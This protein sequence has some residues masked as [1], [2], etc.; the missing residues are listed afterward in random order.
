MDIALLLARLVLTAVFIVSGVGKLADL[1]GSRKATAGFGVPERFVPTAAVL[2]PIAE[3]I[4]A[5]ALLFTA[6]AWWGGL[7]GLALLILFIGVIGFNLA[8]GRTPDCHCFGQLHS[9]PIGWSTIVRNV[10]L[11]A[12]AAF[13]VV[14]GWNDPGTSAFAWL[15]S[16]SGS[17]VALL[18]GG[19]IFA[20]V[21]AASGWVVINLMEQNGRL[22]SRVEA[23]EQS[24]AT[25]SALPVSPPAA[26]TPA[27]RL[28]LEVGA[29]APAFE[30]PDLTGAMH[31]L[32]SVQVSATP[33]LLLFTDPGCD[34]CNRM[35][36]EVARWQRELASQLH[37]VV[38][39]RG[40][41]E[42]N[43]GKSSEHGI[44]QILLQKDREVA[45]SYGAHGTPAAVIVRSDGKIG[46]PVAGGVESIRAL[47]ATVTAHGNAPAGSP[48]APIV[49]SIQT[50]PAPPFV[51]PNL[52]GRTISLSDLRSA[53]LPVVLFFTDARCDPCDLL[54]P[55][56]GGWQTEHRDRITTVLISNGD[57]DVNREKTE[58]HGIKNVLLQK[59]LELV[60]AYGIEQA[61]AVI[62][63]QA[64]GQWD[65]QAAY[66]DVQIR[67]LVE[68]AI[69]RLP[70]QAGSIHASSN[71][72]HALVEPLQVGDVLPSISMPTL[73]GE[74]LDTGEPG[75]KESV[76]LFWNP[77][78]GYCQRM[79]GDL[80][81]WEANQTAESPRLI[82][83]SAGTEES[84]RAH[85]FSSTVVLDHGTGVGRMVGA[86]G[87]PAAVRIDDTGHIASPIAPGMS[88]VLALLNSVAPAPA[89]ANGLS[90]GSIDHAI[91][92]SR[93]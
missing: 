31:S 26:P 47:V 39:S 73:D 74:G 85:G 44:A 90:A 93:S 64:N 34:P 21:L 45:Q 15:T 33:T 86:H 12:V 41:W 22:L 23:I 79:A 43:L 80:K 3:L 68:R 57:A 35:M 7:G 81:Q 50:Q 78:C 29:V 65:G 82:V 48:N 6:S 89:S 54:L 71:P 62:V 28:G 42:V 84:T 75:G 38:V 36:P 8:R 30:L 72:S 16:L 63:I 55:E 53:G 25:G 67:R 4:V 14:G 19:S 77:T 70:S 51:L 5:A 9:K 40:S 24:L 11:S 61:P 83:I 58:A 87:T 20:G 32:N 76:L 17:D 88:A 2:L 46:T 59:E 13:I 52:D 27:V 10:A 18:L 60:N 92:N 66:G 91:S 49:P 56:I 37:V 69:G 1:P